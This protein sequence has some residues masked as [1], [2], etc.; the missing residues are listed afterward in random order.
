MY[1]EIGN[2]RVTSEIMRN[3][4]VIVFFLT[5]NVA[6]QKRRLTESVEHGP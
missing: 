6:R 1:N 4:F 5:R 3:T 2:V